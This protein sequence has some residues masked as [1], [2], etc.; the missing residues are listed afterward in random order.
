MIGGAGQT[1]TFDAVRR[2]GPGDAAAPTSPLVRQALADVY[3]RERILKFLGMRM[4]TAIMHKRG[5]P[6][7]PSVLK[8]FFTQS[9]SKRVELAV[10]LEGAGGMLADKRRHPGRLLAEAVHG[11]VLV[12]HRRRHQ[13]GAP[14]HDRR[15]G[16]RPPAPSPAPTRTSPGASPPQS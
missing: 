9:L 15:A 8:N 2:A 12:P 10:D 4:Q 11:A 6:P 1:S 5:T 16:P 7:D 3:T 14:Q 13:R